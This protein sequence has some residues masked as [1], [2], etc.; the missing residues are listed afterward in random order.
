MW[1]KQH[2]KIK[3]Q[4]EETI[5][6]IYFTLK[7]IFK[8][9]R[10]MIFITQKKYAFLSDIFWKSAKGMHTFTSKNPFKMGRAS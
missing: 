6:Y 5:T 8:A 10:Q 3:K 1:F 7:N 4:Q 2:G 9:S